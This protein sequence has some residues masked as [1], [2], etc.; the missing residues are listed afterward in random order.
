MNNKNLIL[1]ILLIALLFFICI[2]LIGRGH[3]TSSKL[4][5][6]ISYVVVFFS[7]VRLIILFI[8]RKKSK[9]QTT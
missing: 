7:I 4:R 2:L 8:Q 5:A 3:A 9:K 1:E 6:T